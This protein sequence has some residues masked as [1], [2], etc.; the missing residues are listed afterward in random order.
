[1]VAGEDGWRED[2]YR[3]ELLQKR[4]VEGIEWLQERMVAGEDGWSR[5]WL[6]ERMG[7]VEDGWRRGWLDVRMV[8]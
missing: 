6:E 5:G 1:M 7:G 3:R 2:G 8:G 4:I